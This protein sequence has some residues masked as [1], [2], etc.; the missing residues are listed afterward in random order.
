MQSYFHYKPKVVDAF[1]F[2]STSFSFTM[3]IRLQL[4]FLM[5]D[6]LILH[7]QGPFIFPWVVSSI[8]FYSIVI[9]FIKF[10]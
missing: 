6:M 9:K 7:V 5:Y 3:Q 4:S 1:I 8:L 10:K 2:Y